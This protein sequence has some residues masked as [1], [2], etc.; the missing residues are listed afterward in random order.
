MRQALRAAP[1][2]HDP[3]RATRVSEDHIGRGKA[4]VACECEIESSAHAEPAN[5]CDNRLGGIFNRAKN[6]LA[7]ERKF[8]RVR[9]GQFRELRDFQNLSTRCE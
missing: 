5:C 1:A 8:E 2:G 6:A 9:R 3:E 7:V 4:N